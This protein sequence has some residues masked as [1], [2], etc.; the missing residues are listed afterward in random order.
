MANDLQRIG[1]VSVRCNVCGW[2]GTVDD[3]EPDVDGDGSL[4][5][6][7]CNAVVEVLLHG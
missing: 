5:C 4:G 7:A 3:C 6:H 2:E 1:D